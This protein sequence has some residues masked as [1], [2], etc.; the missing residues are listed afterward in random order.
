M[1]QVGHYKDDVTLRNLCG[2]A[3]SCLEGSFSGE[4]SEGGG[5]VLLKGSV[6]FWI[7]CQCWDVM[8]MIPRSL[9]C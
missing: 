9:R 1:I 6:T 7:A 4:F 3:K 2:I 5:A 8:L